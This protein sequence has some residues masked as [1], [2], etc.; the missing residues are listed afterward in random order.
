[1]QETVEKLVRVRAEGQTPNIWLDVIK[2]EECPCTSCNTLN[3]KHL[4]NHDLAQS[5]LADGTLHCR[6]CNTMIVQM[7]SLVKGCMQRGLSMSL[8]YAPGKTTLQK[9]CILLLVALGASFPEDLG[10]TQ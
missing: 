5:A 2:V 6:S 1:M 10:R 9:T 7:N 4:S 3:M 8:V